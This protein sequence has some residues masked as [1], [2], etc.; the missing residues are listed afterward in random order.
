MIRRPPRST[1]TGTLFPY[2]TLFRSIVGSTRKAIEK[3]R[4]AQVPV[5][6]VRIGFSDDYKECPATSRIFSKIRGTGIFRLGAWGTE[7]HPD[8]QPLPGDLDI[9]K[10]RVSPF[11][12]TDLEVVLRTMGVTRS[13]EHTSELPD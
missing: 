3:A 11:H 4:S 6:F 7:I 8:L 5:G 12:G 2:T 10:P 13:D 9:V 1:R